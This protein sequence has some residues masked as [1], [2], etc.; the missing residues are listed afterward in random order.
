MLDYDKALFYYGL[1][2][3]A[4]LVCDSL[5]V[6]LWLP[7]SSNV[8]V[9]SLLEIKFSIITDWYNLCKTWKCA[10]LLSEQVTHD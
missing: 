6:N 2:L 10:G 4:L 7:V 5:S 3:F 8:R 9:Y 1:I